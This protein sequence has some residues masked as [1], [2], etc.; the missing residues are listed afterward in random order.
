MESLRNLPEAARRKLGEIGPV[1]GTDIRRHRDIVL[2]I[3]GPLLAAA[4][5]AGVEVTRGIAYGAHPRHVLDV[6]R[7]ER[8]TSA[9]VVLFVHGGAFVR[10]DKDVTDEVYANV[11][12]YFARHGYLAV[13]VEYR[14][15]PESKYPG[16]AADLRGAV[17]W[18][19]RHAHEHGGDPERLFLVG[20]S[21]GATHVATYAWDPNAALGPDPAV[22][23]LVLISGRLRADAR[24]DNP[25]APA[26][27]A[28]F[29]D[30][31]SRYE[32]LSPVTHA[33]ASPL[34]VFLAIAE[35]ENPLLD[36]YGAEAFHRI[37]AARG[38]A[39]R[40]LRLAR[41]N[42]ISMIAHVNTEEDVLGS[43]MRAFFSAPG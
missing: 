6:Y 43:E 35:Y 22:N 24:P 2:G 41:H 29:G 4:P 8:A 36:V 31:A 11:C 39:P 14:L 10:G 42:H 27:R 28:Y 21:A 9:P 30:D 19:K 17:A 26:V 20:H 16:G 34:P 32:A 18:V 7:H 38:R 3:Y 40:F 15:A 5:K 25:N 23:G 13:N 12:Y 37:A 1:W 33:A